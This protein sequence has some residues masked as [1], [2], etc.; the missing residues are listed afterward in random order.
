M[1]LSLQFESDVVVYERAFF[2]AFDVQKMTASFLF[3]I[4][5][6]FAIQRQSNSPKAEKTQKSFA[7]MYISG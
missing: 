6:H 1:P 7:P 4:S 2:S 3:N 5:L